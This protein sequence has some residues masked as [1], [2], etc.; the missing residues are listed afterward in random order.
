MSCPQFALDN[1]QA[2]RTIFADIMFETVLPANLWSERLQEVQATSSFL[3]PVKPWSCWGLFGTSWPCRSLHIR[4]CQPKNCKPAMTTWHLLNLDVQEVGDAHGSCA[5]PCC[6]WQSYNRHMTWGWCCFKIKQS[7]TVEG[8][9]SLTSRH[10]WWTSHPILHYWCWQHTWQCRRHQPR[11][12]PWP[13]HTHTHTH[14]HGD[15]SWLVLAEV[16]M[17]TWCHCKV[18]GMCW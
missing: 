12:R 18:G 11:H 4:G 15:V 1:L 14:T 7:S 8:F 2:T 17:D 3:E 13:A 16:I 10:S 9:W 6:F 5:K